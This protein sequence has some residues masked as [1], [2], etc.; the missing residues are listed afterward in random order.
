MTC[1]FETT[2]NQ[3]FKHRIMTAAFNNM[4]SEFDFIYFQKSLMY[5]RKFDDGE[6]LSKKNIFTKVALEKKYYTVM[7][8]DHNI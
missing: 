6:K 2:I 1:D 8:E 5:V 3:A 4:N 7:N